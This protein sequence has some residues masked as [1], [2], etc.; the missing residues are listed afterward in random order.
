MRVYFEI[1]IILPL[2]V[3]FYQLYCFSVSSVGVERQERC[4][5]LGIVFMTCGI[6]ALAFKSAPLAFFG[7]IM[8]MFGFRLLAKGLDRMNKN[9]FIDQYQD[10]NTVE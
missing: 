5:G 6:M 3:M 9:T 8:M 1:M 4:Q 10:D 7:L 2:L